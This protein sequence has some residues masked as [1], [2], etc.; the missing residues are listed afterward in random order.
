MLYLISKN[1]AYILAGLAIIF[2]GAL[3]YHNAVD[4]KFV[5]D[6]NVLV[7]DNVYIKSFRH[8]GKIFTK[9][10]GEGVGMEGNS[11]RPL[12]M[13]TYMIG[14]ALWRLDA[15]GYHLINITLH[16]SA[17]IG[18]FWLSLLVF[19]DRTLSLFTALLFVVHPIYTSAVT[20][21]SGA[22]D[23]LAAVFIITSLV[24]Y[25]RL[26]CKELNRKPAAAGYIIVVIS[27]ILA[28]LSRE[29]SLVLPGILALYHYAFKRKINA[30]RFLPIAGIAVLYAVVRLTFLKDTLPHAGSSTVLSRL[31]GFF[32]AVTDYLRLLIAPLHLH[33]EYG[34][35]LFSMFSFKCIAGIF[36]AVFLLAVAVKKRRNSVIFFSITWFFVTLLPLSNIYPLNAYMAEHWLY[37]PAIGFF[38]IAAKGASYLVAIN[39]AGKIAVIIFSIIAAA[40]AFLTIKQNNYWKTPIALYQHT[41]KYAPF[42][43]RVYNNLGIAYQEAGDFDNALAAYSKAV[44]LNPKDAYIYNNAG[45]LYSSNKD[46]H[47][48]ISF[49]KKAVELDP[50]Y[51]QGYYNLGNIYTYNGDYEKAL[52]AYQQAVKNNADFGAAYCNLGIVY[53]YKQD[54][55]KALLFLEKAVRINPYDAD[56]YYNLGNI[57]VSLNKETSALGAYKKAVKNR[58]QYAEAYN[59]L[60]VMHLRR[61]NFKL[62]GQNYKKAKEL[63]IT[64]PV[65]E[66]AFKGGLGG[67]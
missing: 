9:N 18:I 32:C 50:G 1:R 13:L 29:N 20:Y 15:R 10:I 21:I 24:F 56:A 42:S 33:M 63:G 27:Y 48:A 61:K 34:N 25:I 41:L 36:L 62:A 4:A 31:P 53:T 57:Y 22:A 46:Y 19:K 52:A 35:K 28:L 16:I 51:A 54:N 59:N 40:Y 66:R 47:K 5:W 23:P 37:L 44:K 11:Y 55:D 17:A 67:E 65:L 60:A 49:Y 38:L 45:L 26:D 7:R 64:N 12:Q 58:P 3:S 8:I 30:G 14:H 6:D 39:R 43:S 2:A